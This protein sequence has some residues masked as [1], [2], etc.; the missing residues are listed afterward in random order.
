MKETYKTEAADHVWAAIK[1]LL[2]AQI[3]LTK[4]EETENAESLAEY[5]N[6]F[7]SWYYNYFLKK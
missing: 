2:H 6:N 7:V 5:I 4:S 1:E 3:Q